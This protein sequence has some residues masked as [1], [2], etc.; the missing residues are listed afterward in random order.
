MIQRAGRHV[1]ADGAVEEHGP[2]LKETVEG[3][4]GDVRLRPTVATLF[5]VLLEFHPSRR[6]KK[7]N[8]N[9]IITWLITSPLKTS[10]D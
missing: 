5:H 9:N 8:G 4:S 10:R 1:Q 6:K 7:K 3:K 2:E